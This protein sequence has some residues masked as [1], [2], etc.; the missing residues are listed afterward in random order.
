MQLKAYHA[1][2]GWNMW[3]QYISEINYFWML[4]LLLI[5]YTH[6]KME[7]VFHQFFLE[8]HWHYFFLLIGK[9]Q[10]CAFWYS[11]R[12]TNELLW[13]LIRF[14]D[15]LFIEQNSS[16]FFRKQVLLQTQIQQNC[17]KHTFT[18]GIT[19]RVLAHILRLQR[20]HSTP[21][22][23]LRPDN[24]IGAFLVFQI[25]FQKMFCTSD[26]PLWIKQT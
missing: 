25:Y 15:F 10:V 16:A 17:R 12:D 20:K 11:W 9:V 1:E 7:K 23:V 21:V 13:F 8:L 2:P 14:P 22:S 3:S 5:S 6:Q 4:T 24:C 19:V 18:T 26:L